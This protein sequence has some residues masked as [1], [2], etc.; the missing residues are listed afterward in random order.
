M[1]LLFSLILF[2]SDEFQMTSDDVVFLASPYTFDPFIVQM[3]L[4]FSTGARLVIVPDS[5]KMMPSK[6]VH[7]LFDEERV[8][9]L[10]VS[11]S[12][13]PISNNFQIIFSC[14]SP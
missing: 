2:D 7:I 13:A 3:F 6:F 8:T 5:V 4:A 1:T 12:G 14:Q 11:V 10:Q 9:V